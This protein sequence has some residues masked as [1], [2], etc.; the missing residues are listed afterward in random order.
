MFD[1]FLFVL[2]ELIAI[3]WYIRK[4]YQTSLYRFNSYHEFNIL[5]KE[6][7]IFNLKFEYVKLY[8]YTYIQYFK[9]L[10]LIIGIMYHKTIN[11]WYSYCWFGWIS[12]TYTLYY[13]I[14]VR[15]LGPSYEILDYNPDIK[16]GLYKTIGP[17]ML[18]SWILWTLVANSVFLLSIFFLL[19]RF[20]W[21]WF[22]WKYWYIMTLNSCIEMYLITFFSSLY[23]TNIFILANFF[24]LI[25]VTYMD[26]I[27]NSNVNYLNISSIFIYEKYKFLFLW[28]PWHSF[29]NYLTI[30]GIFYILTL[31]SIYNTD[32]TY[33]VV[34]YMIFLIF[35]FASNLIILDLDIFAGLLLLI[36]SVVILMLFFLIIY[37]TPNINFNIK[38]QKWKLYMILFIIVVFLSLYSYLNLGELF[39]QQFSITSNFLDEFYETLNEL[40]INDLTSIF[41]S[42]YITDSLLLI[43]VGIL[44]LIASIICVVLVSFFTK[45]RNINFKNF[46]TIF[47]IAKTCYTFIFLRKQNL[48]K[49]GKNMTSTRIFNKKS[50]NVSNHSEY[51]EK[52][53]IFEQ[54]KNKN[55]TK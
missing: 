52:Q 21:I 28:F 35:L 34:L 25:N 46:L 50:F 9:Q 42:F 20:F 39:F 5:N 18:F 1:I 55:V 37:L 2:E 47:E 45:L 38:N 30:F 41:I 51:K 32:N 17:F 31:F 10:I 24:Y 4:T 54:K 12:L 14:K 26:D 15:D 27:Y 49:Q 3:H 7:I 48:T 8:T 29:F 53:D 43:V 16:M 33:Y 19:N 11:Y 36:E 6:L 13:N 40:F 22:T 44:L 23:N